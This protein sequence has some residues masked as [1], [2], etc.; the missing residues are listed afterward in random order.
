MLS[1]ESLHSGIIINWG[2]IHVGVPQG[3]ILGPL[4]FSVYM[5][6]LPTVTKELWIKFVCWWHCHNIDLSCAEHG[7][8]ED[9]NF[10]YSW[11]CVNLLSL[12]IKKSNAMLVGSRQKLQNHD[13]NVTVDGKPLSHVSSFKYL[14]LYIDE[15]LTW[16]EYTKSVLQR[17]YLDYIYHL[18]PIPKDLLGKL[19][20]IFVLPILDYCDIVWTPSSITHF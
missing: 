18:N 16:R 11:L 17:I 13:F 8:Q 4:L 20:S 9:L 3:S 12:S 6:D 14:G 7:L 1:A 5:N 2:E 15:Y 19:Y 10:V